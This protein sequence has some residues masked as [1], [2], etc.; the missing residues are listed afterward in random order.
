MYTKKTTTSGVHFWSRK[1]P[2][3][4]YTVLAS[5]AVQLDHAIPLRHGTP[6]RSLP[7]PSRIISPCELVSQFL[8]LLLGAPPANRPILDRRT[9]RVIGLERRNNKKLAAAVFSSP[10]Q[11]F[12]G[13]NTTSV[14]LQ[15]PLAWHGLGIPQ[16][17]LMKLRLTVF[18]CS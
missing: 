17:H 9:N 15:M 7:A 3:W 12:A 1:C 4:F 5:P 8:V 11:D 14:C 6:C 2:S 18:H 16:Q 10:G 13:W